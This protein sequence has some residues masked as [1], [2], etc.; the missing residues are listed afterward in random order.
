MK[1]LLLCIIFLFQICDIFNVKKC[2]SNCNTF[3]FQIGAGENNKVPE[4]GFLESG[5]SN[6]TSLVLSG[7]MGGSG[8]AGGN[9]TIIYP[10]HEESRYVLA[11]K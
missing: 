7:G 8:G 5:T 2:L 10:E 3:I 4:L 9:V 11:G 1:R 6:N